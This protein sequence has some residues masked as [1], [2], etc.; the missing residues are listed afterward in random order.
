MSSETIEILTIDNKKFTVPFNSEFTINKLKEEILEK[1]GYPVDQQ[2][3]I[4]IG[5]ELENNRTLN[6]YKINN[7]SRI[8]V[9]LILRGGMMHQSSGHNNYNLIYDS[10]N[11]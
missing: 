6:D 2:R 3:I 8:F 5:K 10:I 9:V 11:K 1:M 7:N 4:F